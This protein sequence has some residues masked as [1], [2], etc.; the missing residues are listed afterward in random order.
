[1]EIGHPAGSVRLRMTFRHIGDGPER[2]AGKA[3]V[4]NK[5]AASLIHR[6]NFRGHEVFHGLNNGFLHVS[7][8][9]QWGLLINEAIA[10]GANAR[11]SCKTADWDATMMRELSRQSIREVA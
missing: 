5:R 10:T 7:T 2:G 4:T 1:M 8:S 6:P 3:A 11:R 9:E